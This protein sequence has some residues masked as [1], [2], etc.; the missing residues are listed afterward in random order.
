M[1]EIREKLSKKL[2]GYR[3]AALVLLLGVVLLLLPTRSERGTD[4]GKTV[5]P[6]SENE[7]LKDMEAQ[8]SDTLSHIEG[9]GK[10]HLMLSVEQGMEK[11][12]KED[13]ELEEG[14]HTG[15][16][17][18]ETVV[19]SA[20][21]RSESLVL[22][23]QAYPIFRGAVVICEGGDNDRV[24]LQIIEAVKVLTGLSSDKITVVKGN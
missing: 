16:R 3:Y 11:R 9:A 14:E 10:L 2:Y 19:L 6:E 5:L 18:Y 22:E 17:R 21:D 1:K 12:F 20:N 24:R 23:T 15:T 8:L 7:W 4:T 13:K